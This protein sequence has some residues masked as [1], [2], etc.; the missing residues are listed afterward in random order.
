MRMLEVE[1][2]G[3]QGSATLSGERVG[4]ILGEGSS[5]WS[6]CR[7]SFE[8]AIPGETSPEMADEE[9]VEAHTGVTST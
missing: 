1:R 7:F 8:H 4:S 9:A 6:W 3:R 5:E 2:A